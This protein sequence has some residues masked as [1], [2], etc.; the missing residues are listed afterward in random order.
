MNQRTT[1]V[2]AALLGALAVILGA[3]GAHALRDLLLRNE[4]THMY[5][6]ASRYHF[7]HVVVLLATGILMNYYN[8]KRL[9]YAA[10]FFSVGMLCFSGSLYTMSFVKISVLGPVTPLG[11][12]FLIAGWITMAIA[13]LK[14]T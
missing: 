4:T 5:E 7:A 10:L 13:F 11:G 6:V 1:L 12:L 3:M 8:S 14:R 9:G 2:T